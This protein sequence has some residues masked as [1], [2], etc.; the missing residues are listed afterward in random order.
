MSV[1]WTK[2]K[3]K[4][5]QDPKFHLLKNTYFWQVLC[6]YI[7]SF[8]AR[9]SHLPPFCLLTNGMNPLKLV[10]I[11][12]VK[13]NYYAGYLKCLTKGNA[14][15]FLFLSK[16]TLMH[17]RDNVVS[18]WWRKMSARKWMECGM[19]GLTLWQRQQMEVLGIFNVQVIFRTAV[20]QFQ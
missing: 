4:K 13:T 14:I 8:V 18:S 20:Y 11:V 3:K 7:L 12:L 9:T 17:Q 6:T 15:C 2:E 10:G 16:A 5:K 1:D 19:S